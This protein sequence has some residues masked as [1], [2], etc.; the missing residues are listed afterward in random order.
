MAWDT[1]ANEGADLFDKGQYNLLKLYHHVDIL[2]W[3]RDGGLRACTLVSSFGSLRLSLWARAEK[4]CVLHHNWSQ[5]QQLG[6]S[7]ALSASSDERGNCS[8]V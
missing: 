8:S 1:L 6:S 2:K 3:F 5:Y 7:T 4:R